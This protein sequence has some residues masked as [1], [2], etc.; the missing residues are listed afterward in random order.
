MKSHF[1][2]HLMQDGRLTF[3]SQLCLL[4][5]GLTLVL[6]AL[7]YSPNKWLM[8]VG[9]VSGCLMAS[10]AGISAKAQV[11]GLRPFTSD[12]LG[13]RK[14]KASYQEDCVE[15]NVTPHKTDDIQNQETS[16]VQ[17]K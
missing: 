4:L 9:V 12:P 11:L 17:K 14:A 6:G 5:G 8:L 7:I 1:Q 15:K 2:I 16:S 3:F 10:I 13:W